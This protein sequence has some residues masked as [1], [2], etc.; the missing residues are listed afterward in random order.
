MTQSL[1]LIRPR[2]LVRTSPSLFLSRHTFKRTLLTPTKAPAS[3]CIQSSD[4]CL[5]SGLQSLFYLVRRSLNWFELAIQVA[6]RASLKTSRPTS[7]SLR[8][9]RVPRSDD[10]LNTHILLHYP[11]VKKS[12]QRAEASTG[13][14]LPANVFI[15]CSL[16]IRPT[17]NHPTHPASSTLT[18][19][20]PRPSQVINPTHNRSDYL[21]TEA[22]RSA[23]VI[24]PL[25]P[26]STARH[27]G[28]IVHLK[29]STPLPP[30]SEY[31]TTETYCLSQVITPLIPP[32]TTRQ[33]K[34]IVQLK[35]NHNG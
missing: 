21:T 25:I 26:A 13:L 19:Q 11:V 20:T 2:Y 16:N 14:S 9:P 4:S 8:Q 6:D 18:T 34:L 29:S 22:H 10:L 15:G 3:R 24:D 28:L 7:P 35:S 5:L 33:H 27:H 17:L 12:L 30:R 1:T 31:S 32:S 23:Q